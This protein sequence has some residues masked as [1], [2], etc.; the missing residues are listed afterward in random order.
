VSS[1]ASLAA[2]H[3]RSAPY[4]YL[5]ERSKR[6]A[7]RGILK[8]LCLP[9]RQVPFAAREMPVA[10]GWG[11]GGLQLTLSCVGPHDTVKV[12]D[13]GDDGS[14]NAVAM[15]ELIASAAGAGTTTLTRDATL[16]Q[17]RHRIPEV[18]LRRD[19]LLILQLPHPEPLRRVVADP[20][21]SAR[22]HEVGDYTAAWLDLYD[23][24]LRHGSPRT[25]ADHPILVADRALASPSPVPRYDVMRLANRPHPI[26]LG[27]GRLQRIVA[28]PPHTD[29]KPLAFVDRPLKPE[30]FGGPCARCGSEGSYRVERGI[31]SGRWE[32]SDTDAC[33]TRR[34]ARAPSGSRP[35]EAPA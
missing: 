22:L 13:Q 19:Q 8:A 5:D 34:E 7:R 4:A 14:F 16:I 2:A 20:R 28:I 23:D 15:R 29:V 3:A 11:S 24:E 10:R 17:S 35:T 6:E 12:I 33:T 1:V 25:G 18:P 9:G 27:A 30:R 21:R 32:C 26:L 31:A